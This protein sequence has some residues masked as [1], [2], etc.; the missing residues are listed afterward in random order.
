[1]VPSF[2][3]LIWV[4]LAELLSFAHGFTQ[5]D[6][7]VVAWL[8][9]PSLATGHNCVRGSCILWRFGFLNL[10]QIWNAQWLASR[11]AAR[12]DCHSTVFVAGEVKARLQNRGLAVSVVCGLRDCMSSF[13]S[14]PRE[15]QR[16][17]VLWKLVSRLQSDTRSSLLERTWSWLSFDGKRLS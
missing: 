17:L 7:V 16:N 9:V 4:L 5:L 2:S 6:Q 15:I 1:M 13:S 11:S 14:G 12:N 3:G 10:I 8:Q